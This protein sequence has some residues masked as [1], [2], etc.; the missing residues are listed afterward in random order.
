MITFVQILLDSALLS[1]S[2]C[3]KPDN[4][5]I[6]GSFIPRNN[7]KRLMPGGGVGLGGGGRGHKISVLSS[8]TDFEGIINATDM[9][10][11]YRN[12]LGRKGEHIKFE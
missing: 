6:V 11:V 5:R 4:S 9:T 7:S 12:S 2:I 3:T 8:D 10:T 1:R